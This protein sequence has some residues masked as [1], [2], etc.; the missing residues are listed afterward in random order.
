[1]LPVLIVAAVVAVLVVGAVAA[2]RWRRRSRGVRSEVHRAIDAK[3]EATAT[4]LGGEYERPSP[5]QGAGG[6]AFGSVRGRMRGCVYTLT[7][8]E[9]TEPPPDKEGLFTHPEFLAT[10]RVLHFGADET[11]VLRGLGLEPPDLD[12]NRLQRAVSDTCAAMSGR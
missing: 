8:V 6:V 4:I 5:A 9:N 1:M 10:V 12:P 2:A 3:L 7:V 11:V